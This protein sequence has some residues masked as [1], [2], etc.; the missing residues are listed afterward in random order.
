MIKAIFDPSTFKLAGPA[1]P[2]RL[3]LDDTLKR[4]ICR[5]KGPCDLNG[6]PNHVYNNHTDPS[7]WKGN[8]SFF[9]YQHGAS[10][11]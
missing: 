3:I 4:A 11:P 8:L 6:Q 10:S 2:P 7:N 9:S 1:V 5:A